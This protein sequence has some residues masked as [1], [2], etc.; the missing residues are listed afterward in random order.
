MSDIAVA[1]QAFWQK[2]FTVLG[3]TFIAFVICYLDRVNISVAAISMQEEFGWSDLTK[4]YVFSF[5][6]WGY[7]IMQVGGGY[8]ANRF[9]GKLV[10]GAAVVFWSLFTL[11]TPSAAFISLPAL[12]AV[13]FLMGVGEA[14]LAPSSFT[15][16]GRWF[17]HNERSRVMGFLSSG[18]TLGTVL[19]LLVGSWLI[20]NYGWQ[21][22]FYAFGGLGFVWAIFW[23]IFAKDQPDQHPTITAEELELIQSGGSVKDRASS[24]PWKMLLARPQ[25]WALCMTGFAASWVLYIF[26]SW[27]PSY[28]SDVHGLNL[29][30]AG[31]F[32]LF[33][34]VTMFVMLN[35]SGWVADAM[36]T[37]GVSTTVTRKIMAGFGL[38]GAAFIMLFLGDVATPEVATLL[39]CA[40]LGVTAFAYACMV[41]NCLDIAP[42]FADIVY[43]VVNSF[44]VLAGAIAAPAAGYIVHV[45]GSYN[46]VFVLTAVVLVAGGLAFTFFGSG[47]TVVD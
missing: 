4:G 38:F 16:V 6:F 14:G 44:G 8:L 34:W 37:R 32:S 39:M 29:T 26:L 27:L 11:L 7:L 45:T 3:L 2:R 15:V 41:P 33:P 13:R 36:I 19:A 31:L 42:R 35:V 9:G 18:S 43:G 17:P 25:L 40:A 12:L 10:L 1:R 20:T 5:F 23:Y 47:E 30:G 46:Y 28:F 22:V 24:V 21:S